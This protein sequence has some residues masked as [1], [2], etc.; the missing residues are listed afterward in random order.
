[1]RA[2]P[3]DRLFLADYMKNEVDKQ[4]KEAKAAAEDYL[5]M[6]RAEGSASLTST[7]FGE[8]AGEYRYS[9]IKAKTEIEYNECDPLGF[10]EWLEANILAARDYA[11]ANPAEFGE[12]FYERT[13]TLP[14][15]I[16]RLEVDVPAR[17]GPPKISTQDRGVIEAWLKDGKKENVFEKVNELLLGDGE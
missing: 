1:M 2:D 10:D 11:R 5:A 9:K 13:G 14:D 15:G 6:K 12:W 7:V 4:Y 16:S 17:S 8:E 3:I